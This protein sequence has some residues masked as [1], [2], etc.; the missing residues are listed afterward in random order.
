VKGT[1]PVDARVRRSSPVVAEK[2][3]TSWKTVEGCRGPSR[4]LAVGP[5]WQNAGGDDF[6]YHGF[7]EVGGGVGFH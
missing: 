2:V 4:R 1:K 7:G 5:G 3:T 6:A